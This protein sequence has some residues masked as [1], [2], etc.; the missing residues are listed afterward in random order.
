[1]MPIKTLACF[2]LVG[3]SISHGDIIENSWKTLPPG[4][5]DLVRPP[6][7]PIG[8]GEAL[9]VGDV[10]FGEIQFDP[11]PVEKPTFQVELTEIRSLLEEIEARRLSFAMPGT[12]Q[13]SAEDRLVVLLARELLKLKEENARLQVEVDALKSKN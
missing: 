3:W 2:L 9:E 12:N 4:S 13:R 7:P 5:T 1:M 11:I 8:L 10:T 6:R